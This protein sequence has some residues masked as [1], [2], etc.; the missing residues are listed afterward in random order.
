M[1]IEAIVF[2]MDGVIIE[3]EHLWDQVRRALASDRG[4]EW[5]PEATSA[6]QGMSTPEWAG[7]LADV[8]GIDTPPEVLATEVLDRMA[9][10]YA[11]DLPLIPGAVQTIRL[12]AQHWPIGLAS[13]SS[14]SLIDVVLRAADLENAFA[15][16]LSTEE[17]AAGKPS[18]VV[19][20][21]VARKLG[22]DPSCAIAVEDSS[23]GLRSAHAAGM[24]V[25]AVPN[26]DYPPAPDAL[27]LADSVVDDIS[28]VTP[29][30]V[31]GL[32]AER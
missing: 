11:V 18:P 30:F 16:T 5:P 19:Y 29:E 6:M 9:E 21:E 2:D 23:N 10:K 15:S 28:A 27:E 7:Y 31:L 32:A 22:V 17:V 4:C 26:R 12:L 24:L 3:S 8:V 1:S 13:S 20:E 25:I 14:R